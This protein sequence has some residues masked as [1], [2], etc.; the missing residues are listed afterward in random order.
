MQQPNITYV[1]YPNGLE[2]QILNYKTNNNHK[3]CIHKFMNKKHQ[4]I[5]LDE[6]SDFENRKNTLSELIKLAEEYGDSENKK[7]KLRNKLNRVIKIVCCCGLICGGIVLT[8]NIM[9]GRY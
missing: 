9:K 7:I 4:P 3:L 8:K 5:S 2:E 1:F 6:V